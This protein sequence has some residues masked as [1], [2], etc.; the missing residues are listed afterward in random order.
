ML[1]NASKEERRRKE[2]EFLV[3]CAAGD[4][5][6]VKTLLAEDIS[7]IKSKDDDGKFSMQLFNNSSKSDLIFIQNQFL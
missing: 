1:T 3:L 6:S 4:L 5:I 7:L 2:D